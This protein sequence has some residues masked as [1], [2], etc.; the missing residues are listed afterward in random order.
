MKLSVP[1]GIPRA[2]IS[3]IEPARSSKSE[4]TERPFLEL[5]QADEAAR[6]SRLSGLFFAGLF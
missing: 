1:I 5:D 3:L 6:S 2:S 4:Q